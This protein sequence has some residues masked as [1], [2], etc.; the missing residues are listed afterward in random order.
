MEYESLL[1][2]EY[3]SS[4]LKGSFSNIN[5]VASHFPNFADK[6]HAL[7]NPKA[8][9]RRPSRVSKSKPQSRNGSRTSR[10]TS[11]AQNRGKK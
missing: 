9:P 4:A 2:E 3:M 5:L 7:N 8:E 6:I 10:K 11:V 1:D